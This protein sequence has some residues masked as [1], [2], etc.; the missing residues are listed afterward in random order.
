MII[1]GDPIYCE[2]YQPP[3]DCQ[4]AFD[5]DPDQLKRST[6]EVVT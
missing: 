1:V 6:L 3:S 2:G 4:V 5:R